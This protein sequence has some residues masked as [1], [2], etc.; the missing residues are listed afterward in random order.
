MDNSADN[1]PADDTDRLKRIAFW[2][3]EYMRRKVIPPEKAGSE[4]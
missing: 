2:Y 4:K 3:W 1:L